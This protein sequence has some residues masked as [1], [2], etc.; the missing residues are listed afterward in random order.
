MHNIDEKFTNWCNSI[1]NQAESIIYEQVLADI[2]LLHQNGVCSFKTML[3]KLK[4]REPAFISSVCHLIFRKPIKGSVNVLRP[5]LNHDSSYVRSQVIWALQRFESTK[6]V[7]DLLKIAETDSDLEIRCGAINTLGFMFNKRAAYRLRRMLKNKTEHDE[8]RA[9][10]AEALANIGDRKSIRLLIAS[11]YDPSPLIR[12]WAC[13]GLGQI[14]HKRSISRL[15]HLSE[16]DN[17]TIIPWYQY[18]MRQ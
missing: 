2:N 7:L 8:I 4:D 9:N 11:T 13:Y 3:D 10:A 17:G 18:V 1:S 5:L 6:A 12:F 14:P 15:K 16:N